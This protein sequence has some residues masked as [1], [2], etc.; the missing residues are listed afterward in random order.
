MAFNLFKEWICLFNMMLVIN[1]QGITF[2][3][4]KSPLNSIFI[5]EHCKLTTL[6]HV[7]TC[8]PLLISRTR[9]WKF[10][11][12]H[13]LFY[14]MNSKYLK[15]QSIYHSNSYT[16]KHRVPI[17]PLSEQLFY[18]YLISAILHTD[19]FGFDPEN[20]EIYRKF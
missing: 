6:W 16:S 2:H 3:S 8:P 15:F 5:L 9:L 18:S 10:F 11:F 19:L 14:Y 1:T 7:A 13:F 4:W 12:Q 20:N 17:L